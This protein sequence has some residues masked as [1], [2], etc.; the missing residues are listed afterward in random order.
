MVVP[1]GSGYLI[2]SDTS[3]RLTGSS[4]RG[5]VIG[6]RYTLPVFGMVKGRDTLYQIVETYWDCAVVTQHLPGELSRLDFRWLPSLGRLRYARRSLM[7]F[8]ED[9]DYGDIAK[10][11]RKYAQSQGL[12]RTLEEKA[13]ETPALKRYV[14]GFEYRW[15]HWEPDQ[16]Q[17][18]LK[19]LDRFQ[20]HDLKVNFFFPKWSSG[21]SQPDD[22]SSW[23]AF[24]LD[25]PVPGGWKTLTRL[26]EKARARGALLK[27]FANN[28]ANL[29]GAPSYDP[30]KASFNEAGT[31]NERASFWGDGLSPLFGPGVLKQ[32]LD[33]AKLKGLPIDA[34][35][36]DGYSFHG[37]HK[38]DFSPQ[39]PVS[40]KLAIEKQLECFLEARR[41]GIMP[42]AELARF[43][44][45]PECDFFFFTD[46]SRDIL[47]VGEP[48]PL[49]QLVFHECYTACFSGGGYGKYDWP[50][51]QNPRLY[52]L[53]FT[54]A[55][56]YNWMLPYK[57]EHP[58][59]G[60][61]GVPIK[62]WDGEQMKQR[63]HWL[64]RW[65]SYY[66]RVA[67]S[68][69]NSHEFLNPERTLQRIRFANGVTA[70][71]DMEK[72]KCR[73]QGVPGFSGDW[74][75]PHEGSL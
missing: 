31:L 41:R 12:F 64:K 3:Q 73:I 67:Y 72:G 40:R 74:E 20:K 54:A 75:K 69:M 15:V 30:A 5:N 51:E 11:Y 9:L 33:S 23:Q 62:E 10:A 42:G 28:N 29:Q 46:W 19:D 13:K 55:P 52:E 43:W 63:I 47:P 58:G 17:E 7:R 70:E 59:T 24:L 21:T 60:M 49:F 25:R 66:Q 4:S 44:S 26:G 68:E 61:T 14:Q 1:H 16:E 22:F 39:H 57:P 48:V 45:V 65:S 18:V 50:E 32:A 36:F 71:F 6:G 56:S 34:L 2:D 53:L 37:G 35:Y 8:A 27:Y 38:E